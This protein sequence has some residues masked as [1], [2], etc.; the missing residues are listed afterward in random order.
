M[1]YSRPLV[2]ILLLTPLVCG[3]PLSKFYPYGVEERDAL[4]PSLQDEQAPEIFLKVPVKF[5]DETYTSIFVNEFGCLTFRF[6]LPEFISMTLPLDYPAIAALYSNIDVKTAGKIYYRESE[7][8]ELLQRADEDVA[9]NFPRL[10]NPF[11]AKSVFIVTWVEV[12]YNGPKANKFNTFQII[13]ISDGE[14]SFVEYLYA[15]NGIQWLQVDPDQLS[16]S[17]AKAQAGLMQD[18]FVYSLPSS[19]TDQAFNLDKTSNTDSPGMWI[20]RVGNLANSGQVETPEPKTR[21]TRESTCVEAAATCHSKADCSDEDTGYCC[22]CKP[23]YYGNGINYNNIPI[24]SYVDTSENNRHY[25]VLTNLPSNLGPSLQLASFWANSVGW[26]FSK[27]ISAPNGYQISGGVFNY[28]A[29]LIF[30]TGQRLHVQEEFFGHDVYD[31]L[32]MQGSI[33]GTAPSIAVGVSPVLEDL[34]QEFTHSS[35]DSEHIFQSQSSHT[36]RLDRNNPPEVT[37]SVIQT[38]QFNEGC[39]SQM[40][41]LVNSRMKSSRNMILYEDHTRILRVAS[42]NKISSLNLNDD[43]CKN[44]FCVANSSCIVEDDKPTCIC[45]RGFQQLYSEDRLQDDFGCFDINECNAGT[46]LCHKNAMC[47]NEIGSYSCQCRPGFT[48]NGHQCTEITVPQT[49]PTSPCESD[50]RACNPPHSTCT[51]L[52]DYRT[53]NCD[54]GYQKDYL[55]DRR[56]AFVCTDV[57]ECMNYPPICNNN[58]DCINRPG[59]YQCQ[60]KRGFSGDGF[61]CEEDSTNFS[62]NNCDTVRCQENAE[63]IEDFTSGPHCNC[64]EGFISKGSICV[65]LDKITCDIA[66]DCSPDAQCILNEA[67]SNHF[68]V[69][70][71]GF[72][73]DGY[74]CFAVEPGRNNESTAPKICIFQ[75]CE[76][77]KGF[78]ESGSICVKQ[79][80]DPSRSRGGVPCNTKTSCHPNAQ[81]VYMSYAQEYLCQCNA[82]YDGNGAECTPVE[83]SCFQV[84]I[85]HPQATCRSDDQSSR[86]YCICNA[87]YTGNG[88]FCELI[89]NPSTYIIPCSEPDIPT[90][91]VKEDGVEETTSSQCGRNAYCAENTDTS[92]F[93]CVCHDGF[94]RDG[95]K[96]RSEQETECDTPCHPN[97]Q[98]TSPDE[99]NE[100]R[101]QA[102]CICNFGYT[103]DGVTE[104]NPESLGC[105]VVKNCHANAECVYN[106]T[107]AGY[108]CQCAQGYVGNGVECHPL[109]S[110]LEDRSLCGKDASCVVASQGHF[111]C[112]CNEGFTGNGIT[113]KPVRKKESD[114]LLVNQGMFMLRVPYQP[115]RT[116]RGRPIINHPNQMLIGITVDCVEGQ[117]YYSS[118][119]DKSSIKRAHLDGKNVEDVITTNIRSPEGLTF[120]WVNRVLYWTDSQMDT[121]SM[122][123]LNDDQPKVIVS[124]DLVNPRGIVVHPYYRKLFWSDWNRSGPKIEWSNLDGTD[125]EIFLKAADLKLPNSL[126]VDFRTDEL[127]WVDADSKSL[128]CMTIRNRVRRKVYSNCTYPFG[129]SITDE[130]YYWTDWKTNRIESANKEGERAPSIALDMMGTTYMYGIAAVP[131]SCPGM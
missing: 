26:L 28:S 87:G 128:E 17:D 36:Y 95:D 115:T 78:V 96:C 15:E 35:T 49:G 97:A 104:C 27:S 34:Q 31:Q 73:G 61:N 76:C 92:T 99:F 93:E 16:L 65:S 110:C 105:N 48:G 10:A 42:T 38:I 98:C 119:A 37:V 124:K 77:P 74:N 58:A 90:K 12:G 56:V 130:K 113:C 121:I 63:C 14:E 84:E 71:D 50:P 111:H 81:C 129:L 21:I 118:V 46:D 94:Y 53:C 62:D 79:D 6:P 4:L 55:D 25:T 70:N 3:V 123:N 19:G 106:A 101:E 39:Y 32:K 52:T 107:S 116:D 112:E 80:S 86:T 11:K 66:Q 57:D 131:S 89:P 22:V 9:R 33:Q 69:C 1:G 47:F 5:F 8:P 68:C 60:C 88:T 108:R 114:F 44:F 40:K 100:S 64:I 29:E 41:K 72:E 54:P 30:S 45:N 51:N 23:G 117:V 82:G 120:D 103:G 24:Q 13:V 122:A 20:F 75:D 43:P 59:T 126:A 83:E 7:D 125:R 127:C 2:I 102:K 91:S 18:D 85:C 67:V 109:K